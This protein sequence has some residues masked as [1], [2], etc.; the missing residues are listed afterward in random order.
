MYRKNRL[1]TV[2][3]VFFAAAVASLAVFQWVE[4]RKAVE[5]S[6]R[7]LEN[8]RAYVFGR[9]KTRPAPYIATGERNPVFIFDSLEQLRDTLTTKGT[10]ADSVVTLF[11]NHRRDFQFPRMHVVLTAPPWLKFL[12]PDLK[13]VRL[14]YNVKLWNNN[15]KRSDNEPGRK[16][17][18]QILKRRFT[19]EGF[20]R[21]FGRRK[22]KPLEER[23]IDASGGHFRDLIY[24]VRETL[25]RADPDK[26]PVSDD[27]VDSAIASYRD[28]FLPIPLADASWLH[29]IGAVRD[30]ILKDRGNDSV[31]RMT[32]FLDNHLALILKN[33]NEW[34]DVH[35]IIRDEIAEIVRRE[36]KA[37]K[38]KDE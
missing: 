8:E 17:L 28:T 14:L 7:V 5:I 12:L 13:K 11:A 32:F 15:D 35:P 4:T 24:L 31:Q 21:Y 23:L 25:L 36:A 34:Y 16:T 1:W 27:G 19:E 30:S 20:E 37:K 38:S 10:V 6:R 33:G 22:N 9:L 18:R 26:L 29:E 2:L 3:A